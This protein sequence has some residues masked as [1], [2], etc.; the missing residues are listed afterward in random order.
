[1]I[2]HFVGKAGVIAFIVL[3]LLLI[4]TTAGAAISLIKFRKTSSGSTLVTSI[5]LN[6]PSSI[7][8]GSI[9]L[10]HIAT[11]GDNYITG[12][13]GWTF[14][15][16]DINGHAGTQD[17]YW[18]LTGASEP[19]SYNWDPGNANFASQVFFEGVIACYS[20]V[21]TV[22]PIDP[23]APSGGGAVGNGTSITAPSIMTQTPGDLV[24]AVFHVTEN[25]WGEGV[26][27]SLPSSLRRRWSFT[28][29]DASF[30]AAVSGDRTQKSGG[31]TGGFTVTT[32]NG[33][34]GD[35][36]VAEL[37]ALQPANPP[38]AIPP[39]GTG[40]SY[41][42]ST[43][44]SSGLNTTANLTLEMPSPA[45]V[46]SGSICLAQLSILGNN[47]INAPTGWT[48]IREVN[49]SFQATQGLYWHLTSST[50]P[51]TYTWTTAGST[52]Y[53]ALISCY[54]GVNRITPVDP[55]ASTGSAS[56]VNGSTVT[57]PSITTVSSGDLV[58]GAFT[59]AE[60]NWGEG[61]IIN[62]PPSLT[63]RSGFSDSSAGFL[64]SAVGDRVQTSAGATGSLT[65][66]TANGNPGDG[67]IAQQV[68]LQR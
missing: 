44:S 60:N 66:T 32:T 21:N 36:L 29:A 46:P 52:Y 6:M 45:A 15:R 10:A 59:V 26:T 8:A 19:A 64:A 18:H 51:P 22:T 31:P 42:A 7:P 39:P 23:G 5:T 4:T 30:L 34:S 56:I 68:A 53:E 48:R 67:L 24:V 57:A 38:P 20:G 49:N 65:I 12:P 54:Y 55:G 1:M 37:F 61:V 25:F 2:S 50:E 63:S 58:L 17:L 33:Q 16:A 27:I 28:D 9:C 40:I 35:G 13:A 3:I 47:S 43:P 11:S 62:L 41:L 14:V